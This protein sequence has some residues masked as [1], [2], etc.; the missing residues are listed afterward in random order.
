LRV[1]VRRL[2]LGRRLLICDLDPFARCRI[3][4]VRPHASPEHRPEQEIERSQR[5]RR[6]VDHV[7]GVRRIIAA[8]RTPHLLLDQRTPTPRRRTPEHAED[9]DDQQHENKQRQHRRASGLP[10]KGTTKTRSGR[11]GRRRP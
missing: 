3:E 4:L 2:G 5:Q 9:N 6:A 1:G 7:V 11:I 8:R 10:W